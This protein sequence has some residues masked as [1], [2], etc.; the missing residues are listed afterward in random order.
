MLLVS[1]RRATRRGALSHLGFMALALSCATVLGGA[2]IDAQAQPY[3]N[4]VIKMIVPFG[5]GGPA[6]MIARPVAEKLGGMLGQAVIV[7]NHAGASGTIAAALVANAPADGYTLLLGTSNEITMSPTLYK[8]L[9]YDPNTA[10]APISIAGEFANVLVVRPNLP[11]QNFEEFV[12]LARGKHLSFASSGVG[13]TNHLTAELFK[14]LAKAEYNHV[15]YKGGGQAVVDVAGGQVDALFATM[16]SAVA[17]VKG[18]K[19]RALVTTGATRAQALP[20]VPTG[21]E[22]GM[23]GLLVNTWNGILAPANTPRPIV[24]KLNAAIVKIVADADFKQK[25]V[26]MGAEARSTSPDEYLAIIRDD[27]KRWAAVIKKAGIKPE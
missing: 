16:P 5:P 24:D 13:S 9:P 11:A 7:E 26:T 12:K 2:S 1:T 21:K 14:D 20:D 10:F 27:Y 18:G 19:M 15:P 6:D 3:P 17:L 25:M 4:K 8:S 23:P 22:V